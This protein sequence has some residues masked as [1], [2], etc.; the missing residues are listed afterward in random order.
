MGRRWKIKEKQLILTNNENP[1]G[2]KHTSVDGTTVK[3]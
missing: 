2:K 1:T 3:K